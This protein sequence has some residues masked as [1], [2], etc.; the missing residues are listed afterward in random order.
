MRTSNLRRVPRVSWSQGRTTD[1]LLPVPGPSD[2]WW[3]QG[4][5]PHR[6]AR[7]I[8]GVDYGQPVIP[9]STVEPKILIEITGRIDP[10]N[11]ISLTYD[12]RGRF[13]VPLACKSPS[14]HGFFD[15]L[16]PS[17]TESVAQSPYT[18]RRT[19]NRTP[20]EGHGTSLS[21]ILLRREYSVKVSEWKSS[22]MSD[23]GLETNWGN[24]TITN[25]VTIRVT[26]SLW[27][28][29]SVTYG[30]GI[31][32]WL[33]KSQMTTTGSHSWDGGKVT[34]RQMHGR[35]FRVTLDWGRYESGVV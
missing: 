13:Q 1:P 9:L 26:S 17:Y 24:R 10:V 12:F 4:I 5:R 23:H 35:R 16:F 15:L 31:I 25:P 2:Q 29:L 3:T 20:R 32:N 7:D 6:G 33:T 28:V 14:R 19:R 18:L 34:L 27:S 22:R 30:T 21:T 8:E 11:S